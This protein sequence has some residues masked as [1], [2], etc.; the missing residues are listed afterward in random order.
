MYRNNR[1]KV[2]TSASNYGRRI[3]SGPESK[4]EFLQGRSVAEIARKWKD[5]GDVIEYD[6]EKFWVIR[7]DDKIQVYE[8]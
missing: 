6:L 7:I 3:F 8:K 4:W 2:K 5:L 1:G